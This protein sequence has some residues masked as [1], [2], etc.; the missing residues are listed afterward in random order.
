M[1]LEQLEQRLKNLPPVSEVRGY[2]LAKLES[3]ASDVSKLSSDIDRELARQ[4][5]FYK[6][7]EEEE[8]TLRQ[9]IKDEFGCE[10]IEELGKLRDKMF[11]EMGALL[12]KING[13]SNQ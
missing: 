12:D 2:D 5:A 11:D 8:K 3:L 6:N 10:N 13:V 4:E 1:E 9:K 7:A